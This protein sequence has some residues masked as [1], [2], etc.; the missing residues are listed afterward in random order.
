M[1]MNLEHKVLNWIE[2]NFDL[3]AGKMTVKNFP[4]F[5][6]GKL[7][8]DQADSRNQMVVYWDILNDQI[9]Q[10]YPQC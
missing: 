4:M 2:D 7:L 5:P 6:G 10:A 3:R 8:I 9:K 1:K